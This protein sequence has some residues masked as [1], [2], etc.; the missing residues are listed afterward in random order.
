MF[1]D[2]RPKLVSCKSKQILFRPKHTRTHEG[3]S[4]FCEKNRCFIGPNRFKPQISQGFTR[5]FQ[6]LRIGLHHPKQLDLPLRGS[7]ERGSPAGDLPAEATYLPLVKLSLLVDDY[8]DLMGTYPLVNIQKAIEH[9][10]RN[11]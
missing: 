5:C 11:S 2:G 6:A 8:N 10:H 9:G 3:A 4:S 7:L 1:Q